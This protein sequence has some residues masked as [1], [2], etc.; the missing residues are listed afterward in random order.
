[1]STYLTTKEAAEYLRTTVGGFDAFVR[2]HGVP[3][4]RYGRHRRF[5]KETLD[6]VLKTMTVRREAGVR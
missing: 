1:M 6:R 2:R 5:L 4:V 3:Y